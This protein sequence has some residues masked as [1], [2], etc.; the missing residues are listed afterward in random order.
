MKKILKKLSR[1]KVLKALFLLPLLISTNLLATGLECDLGVCHYDSG[2]TYQMDYQVR[3]VVA[4]GDIVFAATKGGHII[5]IN[6]E[7]S[8]NPVVLRDFPVNE[9]F[10]DLVAYNGYLFAST[11]GSIIGWNIEDLINSNPGTPDFNESLP[12]PVYDLEVVNGALYAGAGDGIHVFS[13]ADGVIS[14]TSAITDISDVVSL[15]QDGA[16]ILAGHSS[17]VVVIDAVNPF[18]PFID[19]SRAIDYPNLRAMTVAGSKIYA[20]SFNEAAVF[21]I[22]TF[23]DKGASFIDCESFPDIYAPEITHNGSAAYLGCGT[24]TYEITET[25]G[26][27]DFISKDNNICLYS[28]EFRVGGLAFIFSDSLTFYPTMYGIP[29]RLLFYVGKSDKKP[30]NS[31]SWCP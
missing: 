10:Y 26:Y 25:G 23:E 11:A 5:V 6:A 9:T 30:S 18:D 21:D 20:Y 15:K 19:S 28:E 3:R 2:T 29:Y 13:L 14:E 27:V 8:S 16:F 4:D 12:G 24:G 1:F 7:D 31:R 17:G 22:N